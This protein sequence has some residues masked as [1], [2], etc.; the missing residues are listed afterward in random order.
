MTA[1][2]NALETIA[3]NAKDREEPVV[4]RMMFGNIVGMPV[5][6]NAISRALVKKIDPSANIH[7]W[8][9]AWRRGVSWN[10]AKIIVS[11]PR[12]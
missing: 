2:Q 12:T 1:F 4:I 7:L 6:C 3:Q 10:H 9:G 5:N 11:A 8:V